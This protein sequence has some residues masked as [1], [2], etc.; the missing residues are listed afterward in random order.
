MNRFAFVF[1]ALSLAPFGA[2]ADDSKCELAVVDAEYAVEELVCKPAFSST[3][4]I[5]DGTGKEIMIEDPSLQGDVG[6]IGV[7]L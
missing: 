2:F 6:A 4:A 1:A 3:D 5:T 7:A